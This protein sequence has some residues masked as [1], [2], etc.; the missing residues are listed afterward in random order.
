[1]AAHQLTD[2]ERDLCDRFE[3]FLKSLMTPA[4]SSVSVSYIRNFVTASCQDGYQ[5]YSGDYDAGPSLADRLQSALDQHGAN[6]LN[7][8]ERRARRLADLRAELAKLE[9]AA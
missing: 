9:Q 4:H 1:M 8:E 5:A 3:A 2:A 6:H 7:D